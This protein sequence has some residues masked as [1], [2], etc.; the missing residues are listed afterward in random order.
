MNELNNIPKLSDSTEPAIDYSTCYTLPFSEVYNEDCIEVMKRYPDKHFELAVVDPPYGLGD[1]LSNGSGKR[2][3]DPSRLLY[4]EKNWDVLPTA[5]YWKELFRVSKNQVVFGANYFL[6][7]LPNTRGFVCWDK[8][9]D[10]PTLSACE[11]VWTSFNKPAKIMKKSSMDL[12]RFHPTQKPIYIYDWM[13][14]YC[15]IQENDKIIDTHLGSGSSRI[16]ANKN[17]LNFVGCEID[18]EYFNKQNKRY[19]DFISQTRLF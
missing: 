9:Q 4:V 18:A 6:E 15:K 3:N 11:L 17:K 10:M 13:F 2:K 7:F 19:A 8:K 5:E 16:S 1:R 14:K 12:E